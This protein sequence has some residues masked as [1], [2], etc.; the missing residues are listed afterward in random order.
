VR[1]A[2]V[3]GVWVCTKRT[4]QARTEDQ[5][6]F[7]IDCASVLLCRHAHT[8]LHTL[9]LVR[10]PRLPTNFRRLARVLSQP[11][12]RGGQLEWAEGWT[13]ILGRSR[14]REFFSDRLDRLIVPS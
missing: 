10:V 3:V 1:T 9:R 7:C 8:E 13:V 11:R 14:G 2:T 6:N 4:S 5:K 12:L